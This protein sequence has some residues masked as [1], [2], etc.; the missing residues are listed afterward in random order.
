M[1]S[2]EMCNGPDVTLEVDGHK[3]HCQR[4]ELASRSPYFEAMFSPNFMEKEQKIIPIK[5]VDAVAMRFILNWSNDSSQIESLKEEDI[6]AVIQAADL[7]QYHQLKKTCE[8]IMVQRWLSPESCLL[9]AATADQL[10]LT[11]LYQKAFTLAL[12]TFSE[13]RH[14]QAFLELPL[15]NLVHYLT[16]EAL[17]LG[18]NGDEF[19][20]FEGVSCW[21]DHK[22][23]D[24]K[25]E[26]LD[27]LSCIRMRYI[28]ISDLKSMLHYTC[29]ESCDEA[30]LLIKC[31]LCIRNGVDISVE[32]INEKE[33]PKVVTE[34]DVSDIDSGCCDQ[35][36]RIAETLSCRSEVPEVSSVKAADDV[37][38]LSNFKKFPSSIVSRA[39]RILR[40]KERVLPTVACIIGHVI[41]E[42]RKLTQIEENDSPSNNI[43][44][45]NKKGKRDRSGSPCIFIWDHSRSEKPIQLL[46][47]TKIDQGPTEALGYTVVTRG[48]DLY[49]IGG[50]YLLGYGNW[51][52]SVWKYNVWS[53]TWS[54]ET[55][56]AVPRRHHSVVCLDNDLY[57]IGGCGKFRVI[58][59]SV[60]RYDFSTRTWH[61]C[62]P[63]PSSLYSAATCVH[64]NLIY[65]I[66]CQV[67]CYYPTSNSWATLNDVNIPAGMSFNT[68]MPYGEHIFLTGCYSSDLMCYD[69]IREKSMRQIGSFQ[70]PAGD[71][72]LVGS[73]IYSFSENNDV[74]CIEM[75]DIEANSFK[76]LWT[77]GAKDKNISFKKLGGCFPLILYETLWNGSTGNKKD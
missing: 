47:L 61:K 45:K 6:L 58:M 40:S 74:P 30:H 41:E 43:A 37:S 71:A 3:F 10:S 64:K 39:E 32:E 65:V 14:T 11:K 44:K 72:C 17:F 50:E 55:S 42:E 67:F 75:Y 48:Q 52:K 28:S 24:R 63:L 51:N 68:A 18:P 66:S 4:N 34:D 12:W 46:P 57:I 2:S 77:G 29:V 21:L 13:V 76:V 23:S 27:A 33:A 59:D 62:A 35:F 69:P 16:Q 73:K 26:T 56:L 49:V 25:S 19:Q 38:E 53:E 20:V 5:D 9:T 1:A 54:F 60:D 22:V 36:K 7:L 31:V 15:D 70:N 8:E